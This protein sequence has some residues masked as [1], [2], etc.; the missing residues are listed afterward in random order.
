MVLGCASMLIQ[1]MAGD[2]SLGR[3]EMTKNFVQASELLGHTPPL[4]LM[5]IAKYRGKN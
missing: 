2:E 5:E 1:V 4:A 3:C